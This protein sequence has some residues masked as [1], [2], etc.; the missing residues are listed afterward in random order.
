MATQTRKQREVQDREAQILMLARPILL[1]EGYQALS[2]DRLAGLM[3][4]AKGT[5][6]NHF[7]N[8]EEIVLALAIESMELRF[9]IF[10]AASMLSTKS[11]IRLMG[12]GAACELYT[13][14]YRDHFA[15]E[16][17]IRNSTIWDK[18]STKRQDLIRHCESRCMGVV[19]GIVRDGVVHGDLKLRDGLSAEEMIFGFWSLNYGSQVL[20][21]T[22]PSLAS[23]G[24]PDAP[25]A[26]R[27]H[28]YTLMNGFDWKPLLV[29]DEH[30]QM[31]DELRAK[32][33]VRF[34]ASVE[35]LSA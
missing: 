21:A 4:Y 24:I 12:I 19:A 10:E 11:R 23:L 8:K 7:P 35:I 20:A 30:N 6:Y 9:Q 25:K 22:S 2:M 18:S 3:E 34:Q 32:L 33:T 13:Q 31:M 15:I 1:R 27:H 29:F 5:L 28:C 16:E 14:Q 17:W 26:I